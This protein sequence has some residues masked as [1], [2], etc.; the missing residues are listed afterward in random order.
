M[1]GEHS[2]HPPGPIHHDQDRAARIAGMQARVTEG[3]DSGVGDHS[4]A[5]LLRIA[6]DKDRSRCREQPSRE[7]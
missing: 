2:E 5:D 6:R 1:T 4:M 7:S 3:L